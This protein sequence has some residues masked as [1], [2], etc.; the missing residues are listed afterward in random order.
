MQNSMGFTIRE[1][2]RVDSGRFDAE[3][4]KAFRTKDLMM[5]TTDKGLTLNPKAI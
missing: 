4:D 5:A 3:M 1:N 2:L